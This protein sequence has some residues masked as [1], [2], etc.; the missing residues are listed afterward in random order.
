MQAPMFFWATMTAPV[1]LAVLLN[2][3]VTAGLISLAFMAGL[4]TSMVVYRCLFHPLNQ[5]PGPPLAR[6]SKLYH[7]YQCLTQNSYEILAQW[8]AQY[9]P[10]VRVGKLV[11]CL[12]IPISRASN[13]VKQGRMKFLSL[14]PVPRMQSMECTVLALKPLGMRWETQWSLCIQYG[15]GVSMMNDVASGIRVFHQR[16]CMGVA[17]GKLVIA[18]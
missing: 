6:V 7:A 11:W 3:W 8:H 10:A 18:R 2:A 17:Q 13:V 15:Q 1:V 9:G 4:M 12:S 16:V 5:F 14:I